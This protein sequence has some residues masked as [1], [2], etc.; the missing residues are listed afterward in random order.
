VIADAIVIALLAASAGL[1]LLC[2]VGVLAMR[3]TYD[4]LHYTGP[5]SLALLA[6]ALAILVEEGFSII[7][8]KALLLAVF[9]VCTSP[10]LV[11]VTARAARI[12]EHGDWTVAPE[13]RVEVE[14]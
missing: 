7:A 5:V 10:V 13:A 14:E 1:M 4:R 8:N 3:D 6:A 12:R 11:H 9:Q 2:A